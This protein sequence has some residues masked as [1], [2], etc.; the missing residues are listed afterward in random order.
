[1]RRRHVTLSR[2][3]QKRIF[4]QDQSAINC[5]LCCTP[6]PSD[7]ESMPNLFV[8]DEQE[9]MILALHGDC[10]ARVIAGLQL[11]YKTLVH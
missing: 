4:M 11:G 3:S 9:R 10:V 1:M 6:L 5:S 8:H 7:E 2:N